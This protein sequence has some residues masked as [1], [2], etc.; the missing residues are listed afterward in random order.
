[1]PVRGHALTS[2]GYVPRRGFT[3]CSPL[4]VTNEAGGA[5]TSRAEPGAGAVDRP[6]RLPPPRLRLVEQALDGGALGVDETF[7]PHPHEADPGPLETQRVIYAMLALL[8]VYFVIM[9]ARLARLER[10]LVELNAAQ[11]TPRDE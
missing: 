9:A 4:P 2:S 10:D 11:E 8:M 5:H 6:V 3:T 7:H 1:M